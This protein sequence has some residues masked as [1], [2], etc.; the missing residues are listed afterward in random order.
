MLHI[1]LKKILREEKLL[2]IIINFKKNKYYETH[3]NTIII[4]FHDFII[5]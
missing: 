2:K 1:Y 4:N 3:T 5:M